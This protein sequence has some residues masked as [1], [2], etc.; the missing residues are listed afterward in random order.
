MKTLLNPEFSHLEADVNRIVAGFDTC[1]P[2]IYGGRNHIR[3]ARAADGTLLNVKRYR[4]PALLNRIVYTLFR[5]PKGLRSFRY[6]GRLLSSGVS[7]PRAVAYVEEHG[8]LGLIGLSYL[9]TLQ[10]PLSRNFYE[11]GDKPMTD[12]ADVEIVRQFARFTA[13]MHGAGILHRD[14]SPGNILFDTDSEGSAAFTVVDT[15]RISFGKVSLHRGVANLA[16]LWGQPEFFRILAEAYCEARGESVAIPD[17]MRT[18]T[19]ARR[20]F[21]TRFARRHPVKFTLRY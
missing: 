14:Y 8:A 2:L 19:A 11:F 21:W 5:A 18:I 10:S 12:A 1:G 20:R 15:N 9:V 16:R 13:A 4:R 6:A 7:T 3:V 17:A